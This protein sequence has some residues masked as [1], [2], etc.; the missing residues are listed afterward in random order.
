MDKSEALCGGTGGQTARSV[1]TLSLMSMDVERTGA[2]CSH[3]VLRPMQAAMGCGC[4]SPVFRDTWPPY[5]AH[6][7]FQRQRCGSERT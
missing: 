4:A 2:V 1:P 7:N 3:H 5:T 6:D